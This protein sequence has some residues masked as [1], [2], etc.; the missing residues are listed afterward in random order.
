[1]FRTSPHRRQPRPGLRALVGMLIGI[2]LLALAGQA[3]QSGRVGATT[4][5]VATTEDGRSVADDP[6]YVPAIDSSRI[7]ATVQTGEAEIVSCEID[8]NNQLSVAISVTRTDEQVY[9]YSEVL[10]TYETAEAEAKH[11]LV[12]GATAGTEAET[13]TGIVPGQATALVSA[14][15]V[16]SVVGYVPIP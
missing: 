14:C 1:M 8:D 12:V 2:A 13:F 11:V 10:I 4:A 3:L 16:V 15:E 7:E 6:T 5:S 9:D